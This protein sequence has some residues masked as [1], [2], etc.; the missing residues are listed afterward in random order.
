MTTPLRSIE[1]PLKAGGTLA[2][3]EAGAGSTL[4]CVHGFPL[5]HSMWHH[6][7]TGLA[8]HARVIAPDLRGF[9]GSTGTPPVESLDDFASDLV[10]LLDH[11]GIH[12][13]VVFCGLSMG[14]YIAF[15]FASIAA[16]R[17]RGLVFCDT[18]A[19]ADSPEASANRH[20]MVEIVRRGGVKTVAD[21]MHGKLF[22]ADTYVELAAIVE[23]TRNVMLTACGETVAAA[24][25]AMA[26]RPD[27]TPALSQ[28]PCPSLW[29][30]GSEDSITPATE[31]QANAER[32]RDSQFV[33]IA[34]A[35]HMAPLE[36]P[37][38]VNKAIERFLFSLEQR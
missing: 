18:R 29:L 24:L 19:A 2:A 17:L 1:V 23:D 26:A 14:G 36:Q 8:A 16:D 15:R 10:E 25:L 35:G 6:Q 30:C 38:A 13:P 27:S 4:L 7:L 20:R 5:D 37:A 22:A 3:M 34:A 32:A 12:E 31:M 9:G 21:A 28:L 33:E 11:L